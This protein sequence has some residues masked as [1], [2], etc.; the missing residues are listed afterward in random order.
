MPVYRYKGYDATSGATRKGSVEAESAKAARQ[1]LKQKDKI[2]VSEIT[3]EVE[4]AKIKKTRSMFGN[5]VNTQDI[6]IMTRQ[7]ATL[8]VAHLPLDETLKALT[9][10]VENDVLRNALNNVKEQISEGKSLHEAIGAFPSIFDRLYVNMVKAGESSGTLGLVL[11]RVADFIEYTVKVRGQISG[12]MMYPVVM[13]GAMSVIT[14]FMF[15]AVVPKMQKIF[16]SL[17]VKL[18][19]YTELLISVSE[20]M[21]SRWYLL[22]AGA[23]FAVW[24]GRKW[25]QSPAGRRKFDEKILKVPIFGPIVMRI[26]VSQFTRT[27][28]TLLASGVPILGAIEITRNIIGNTLIAEALDAARTAVQEGQ[29]LGVS[30]EKSQLF[31]PLVTYMIMTGEKTGQLEEMLQ[32]VAVAYDAEVERKVEALIGLI[33]PAMVILMTVGG[34][35]LLAALMIPMLSI[36]NQMR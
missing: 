9:N 22:I 8:Q 28:S 34:G 16:Q 7:F 21:Q 20:F 30:I 1:K 13:I 12:A 14:G 15:V 24:F 18:P 6:A 26:N 19:W 4:L 3:E 25:Y 10:Q 36:M 17:K 5:R 35:G 2:L 23:A 31:P 33:E 11:Q 27:L 32:H 29:S